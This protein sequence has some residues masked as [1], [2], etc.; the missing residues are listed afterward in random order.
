M[1]IKS[2][3]L[4]LAVAASLGSTAKATELVMNGNLE[5]SGYASGTT[6]SITNAW[7]PC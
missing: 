1:N 3:V 2:L 7:C 5:L 4:G 6:Y